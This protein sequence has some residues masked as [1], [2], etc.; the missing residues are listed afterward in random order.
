MVNPAADAQQRYIAQ[1][2]AL[3][4]DG[5]SVD[6]V[7][8]PA[9]HPPA[10][11]RAKA[12]AFY[13]QQPH[14]MVGHDL[15]WNER[16]SLWVDVAKAVP[17][18]VGHEQPKLPGDMGFY[19]L[20]SSDV[21]RRQ[22]ELA[23]LHGVYGFC[24]RYPWPR[25][26][27]LDEAV[28]HRPLLQYVADAT[29]DFPFC[30]SLADADESTGR[31]AGGDRL[32]ECLLPY[33]HDH[34]YI[35]IDARPLV[36]V[37]CQLQRIDARGLALWRAWC[38]DAGLGEMF[39]VA[40]QCESAAIAA[41][42]FDAVLE[43]PTQN[44]DDC[45]R[46]GLAPINAQ[47]DV[48]NPNYAG[49][50]FD[51]RALAARTQGRAKPNA[52]TC[53]GVMPGWD[54]DASR[55]GHGCSFAHAS[56]AAYRQWL[57]T[58]ADFAE[59]HPV[60]GEPL[61]FIDAWNAWTQG[62]YLEPDRRYGYAYLHATR[63]ALRL[64]PPIA[65][66]ALISHDAHPHG[67]QYLA[68]NLLREF[69]RMRIDIEVLMQGGGWL[70][71][72]FEVLA[73]IHR[74]YEM[75][76]TQLDALAED[77]R[78]RGVDTVI[79]N[80]A[81]SGRV[82]AVFHRAGMRV[83][84]LIHEL[85]GLIAG[86]G[87]E[88]ALS[89]LV[90][91]S[92]RIVVS[93]HAVRDGLLASLPNGAIEHKLILRPQ[94]LF[95]RNRYRGLN[96]VT[97]PRVRLRQ[98]LGIPDTVGV[99]LSIGYADARKGADLLAQAAVRV[100]AQRADMHIVWVGHRDPALSPA[101]NILL[102]DAGIT[103]RVH[104]VGLDFDTDDYYAGADVYALA[105]RE[106]PFPS[107]V[108]ESLAVGTPVVAFAGTGGAADLIA[109]HAELGMVVDAFDIDAYAAALLRIVNDIALRARYGEAGREL[110]NREFSF[111]R[112]AMDLLEIC[113]IVLPRVSAVVPN[114][115]YARY[116]PE[117]LDSLSSQTLP[118][119]EILVLDD[120]STDDS[121]EVLRLQRECCHPD[122]VIVVNDQ[123]S[124]SV[125]RQWLAG[126]RR[127]S[128]EYVWIAEA[129]D[130]AQPE[131]I[132]ILM[133]A[134][135]ADTGIVMA[136]C[137]SELID[138]DS[139]TVAADYLPYTDTLSQTRWR[140]AYT[141]NGAEEAEHGMAI[142]NTVPNVS[143]VLFRRTALLHVL[144]R[145]AEEIASYRIAGDWVVYLRLLGLGRLHFEPRAL[146]RHRRHGSS[147]TTALDLQQHYDE[148]VAVQALAK[149]LYP[150][151]AKTIASAAD[152]AAN[153]RAH[154]GLVADA[155]ASVSM[156]T[157][158]ETS[159]IETSADASINVETNATQIASTPMSN[160]APMS[161]DVPI[162]R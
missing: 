81:V 148:V 78:H 152:Y 43:W 125:F 139:L 41:E 84:S 13:Q 113:G 73:P 79:A 47:L 95:T 153:L 60:G 136:Y 38:R 103:E 127:A 86:Y 154:F 34:R 110:I 128:G 75:D 98:R 29:I 107:V 23:K 100:C 39:F 66:L 76:A 67:A 143:A 83:V 156:N 48:I 116:L 65:K 40:T 52:P 10:A 151:S 94:G 14:P 53:L 142:K 42:G 101:I 123:N 157:S 59:A 57:S 133:A 56:P 145:Y 64:P 1:I 71:Q 160:R 32:I 131:M 104:F 44:I 119:A 18:F 74:L 31:N 16:D 88:G 158:V 162:E 93:S 121:L 72:D 159:A 140:A 77:L 50:V 150:L 132:A 36:I 115:N 85:P 91:A 122:P 51:Y 124:G 105:S 109:D 15:R 146:N 147:V 90:N 129:D 35:C 6:C 134:M 5:R 102:Q 20:Q 70:E 24:F 21:I 82:I 19:D 9:E 120:A 2:L 17:Q 4:S 37:A 26:E 137:Q 111:R 49:T 135:R 3:A 92:E 27:A 130:A 28:D 62:A 114:Y 118:L 30:L 63:A 138:A 112:Y 126:V 8:M 144:E 80:T 96:D 11:V 54:D 12:I 117:R 161:A 155:A 33:I 46:S 22:V 69:K 149:R 89:E 25:K 87:L 55:P 141:A 106:D 108:L 99:V 97:D 45:L 61:I 7:A 58:A 68:L